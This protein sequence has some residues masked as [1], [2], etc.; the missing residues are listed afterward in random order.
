MRSAVILA[1]GAFPESAY[2]LDLLRHAEYLVCCDGAAAHVANIRMPDAIVGDMD[3]LDEALQRRFESIIH[4]ESEQE[5]NDLCKAFRFVL[6]KGFRHIVIL[7][8]TGKREDHTLGNLGHLTDFAREIPD[9]RIVTD[10]GEF[11]ALLTSPATVNS[12]TG[13]K[14]SIFSTNPATAIT[15]K[16]LKYP[17]KSLKLTSWWQGTLNEAESESFTLE[18]TPAS[19]LLLFKSRH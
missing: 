16:G 10:N 14:I 4:R 19:P 1:D 6:A 9:I 18:F 15:S 17:L 12:F 13:Q 8:A 7:G 5:T 2:C 3:T 11:I